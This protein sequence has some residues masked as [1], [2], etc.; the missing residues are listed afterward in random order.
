[1][2][3]VS[4]G[5]KITNERYESQYIQ[6]IPRSLKKFKKLRGLFYKLQHDMG[7]L[8][9]IKRKNEEVSYLNK[10]EPYEIVPYE[11]LWI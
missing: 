8:L 1:M 4:D 7:K 3:E 9:Q 6:N 10:I 5:F 2:V 11:P